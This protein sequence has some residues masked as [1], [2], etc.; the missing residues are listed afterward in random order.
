MPKM[1]DSDRTEI[2]LSKIKLTG[3]KYTGDHRIGINY[4][5]DSVQVETT[6]SYGTQTDAK[7]STFDVAAF[8]AFVV[9]TFVAVKGHLGFDYVMLLRY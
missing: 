4:M 2:N 6:L 8:D 7:A 3:L 1:N 9:A 5:L